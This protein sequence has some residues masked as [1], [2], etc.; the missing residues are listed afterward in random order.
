MEAQQLHVV[1]RVQRNQ[2]RRLGAGHLRGQP[3]THPEPPPRQVRRRDGQ[4]VVHW[5]L[6]EATPAADA[7]VQRQL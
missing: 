1:P 5:K 2:P 4:H 7:E 3:D 6:Q